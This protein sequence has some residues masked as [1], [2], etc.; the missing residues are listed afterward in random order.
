MHYFMYFYAIKFSKSYFLELK[1]IE[2]YVRIYLVA[3]TKKTEG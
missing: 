1:N 2:L 3:P